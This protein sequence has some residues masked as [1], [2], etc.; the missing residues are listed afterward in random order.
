MRLKAR[1]ISARG[2][3]LRLIL[4]GERVLTAGRALT[5]WQGAWLLPPAI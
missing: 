3:E 2:G 5:L 4:Q 1:Q